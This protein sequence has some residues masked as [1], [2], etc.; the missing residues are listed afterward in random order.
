MARVPVMSVMN[1][2]SKMSELVW[3]EKL[4]STGQ[5]NSSECA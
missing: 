4:V 1:Y 3:D 2:A 5:Q